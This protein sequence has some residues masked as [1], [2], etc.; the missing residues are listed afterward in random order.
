MFPGASFLLREFFSMLVV[1]LG[2][3]TTPAFTVTT[4]NINAD[5]VMMR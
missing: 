2:L 4:R 1:L 5:N 3:V